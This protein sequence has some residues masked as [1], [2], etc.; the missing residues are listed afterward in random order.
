MFTLVERV[1]PQARQMAQWQKEASQ[2]EGAQK[3]GTIVVIGKQFQAQEEVR[4]QFES[5]ETPTTRE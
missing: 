1:A 4:R 3:L 2:T 5:G